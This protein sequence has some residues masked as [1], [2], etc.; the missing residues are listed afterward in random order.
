MTEK[1]VFFLARTPRASDTA[2]EQHAHGQGDNPGEK[3]ALRRE[4]VDEC[5]HRWSLVEFLVDQ[6]PHF[7]RRNS[8]IGSFPGVENQREKHIG[9]E[10]LRQV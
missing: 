9:R 1:I 5:A 7:F 3:Q 6:S 4:H 10:L 2:E 8:D